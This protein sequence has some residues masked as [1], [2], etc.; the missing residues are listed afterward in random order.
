MQARHWP[1]RGK[2]S[3]TAY[4]MLA[5]LPAESGLP[6][7]V[8]NVITSDL[9]RGAVDR[10][11]IALSDCVDTIAFTGPTAA[12]R[13]VMR[14]AAGNNKRV[15]L[16]L[17][18]KSANIVFEDA[19]FEEA[20]IAASKAFC[21]NSGQQCSA[22]TRLLVQRSIHERFMAA[23]LVHAKIQVLGDPS[24]PR[25]TMGPIVSEE[26]FKRVVS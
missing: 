18:G 13:A 15:S 10:Q 9:E 23:V 16:E 3:A 7:G 12:G 8:F 14:A 22:G 17:G 2:L 20:A 26:Q 19:P 25:T 1:W 11:V 5:G 24:D 4:A 21:F 6:G